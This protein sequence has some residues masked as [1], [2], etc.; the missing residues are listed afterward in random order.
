MTYA[1]SAG[2]QK[3]V[4][5]RLAA[6]TVLQSLVGAAIFDAPPAGTIP[7]I[8]VS[9]GPETV[10]D[11]SDKTGAGAVH[12]FTVSV[13]T[14][15]ASFHEAK[16]AAGAVAD[17]LNDAPLVLDRGQLT[18]LY[19]QRATARRDRTLARRRIDLTFRASIDDA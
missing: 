17:A 8:Y 5:E 14:D 15:T 4:Y 18:S 13:V 12:R 2:L 16:Q 7:E 19:F 10:S 1:L 11:R 9:L 6:D 3:A